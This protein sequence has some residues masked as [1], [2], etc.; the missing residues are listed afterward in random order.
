MKSFG[1][2]DSPARARVRSLVSASTNVALIGGFVV[3]AA[4]SVR[5]ASSDYFYRQETIRATET[6]IAYTPGQAEAYLRLAILEPDRNSRRAMEALQQA[7]ALNPSDGPSW[8]EL[9]LRHEAGGELTSAE[10]CF[11]RAAREDKQY[12]PRWTLA[13]FY[14]R[15]ND[16]ARFW[17]WAKESAAVVYGDPRS[18]F[19]LC[20]KVAEDGN[21]IDRLQI[22]RPDVRAQYLAYILSLN[23]IGL[24]GPSSRR[25][26]QDTRESDVAVLLQVCDRLLDNQ[27]T[28]DGLEIWNRLAASHRIPSGPVA[29]ASGTVL[30]NGNFASQPTSH[31]IDWRLRQVVGVISSFE[32]DPPGLRITFSGRQEERSEPLMQLAPVQGNT[33]YRLTCQLRTSGIPPNT[34]LHWNISDMDGHT[35]KDSASLSSETDAHEMSFL[36]PPACK[37]VR[38]ALRYERTPGTTRV[39]GYV[40]LREVELN[41]MS[42]PHI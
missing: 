35:L 37:M 34:G 13:N 25:L 38:L 9:G 24:L 18:L 31:G 20:G 29:A 3:A 11:L 1:A 39:E 17:A 23:Q 40:I 2:V 14:L 21:L 27:R 16:N 10:R 8:I 26:L 7:L 32:E 41:A 4:W 36:A 42:N 19:R 5:L 22:A 12:L 33:T 28:N 6:A 30:T 15:R